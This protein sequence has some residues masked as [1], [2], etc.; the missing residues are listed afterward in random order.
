MSFTVKY[1]PS[2]MDENPKELQLS[3]GEFVTVN[4]IKSKIEEFL[5]PDKD[6]N[7]DWIEPFL[8]TVT[9]KQAID[10]I[11]D[12]RF[13]KALGIEKNGQEIVAYEREPLSQ[14]DLK[15]TD[16]VMDFVLC[17]LRMVQPRK[18]IM[19][20]FS[21]IQPIGYSRLHLFRKE[22]TCRKLRIRIYELVRPLIK[23]V[24]QKRGSNVSSSSLDQEYN[25]MFLDSRG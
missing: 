5:K 9:N 11:V 21:A 13:V 12:E 23:S 10:L 15:K 6:P 19:G 1:I 25:Q 17:E 3:V 20:L 8:T 18:S 14:F 2:R 16:D 4:E 7:D 22:W 24:I